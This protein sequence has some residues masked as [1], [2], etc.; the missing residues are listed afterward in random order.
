GTIIVERGRTLR[1]RVVDST[2]RGVAGARVMVG[3]AGVYGGMGRFDEPYFELAGAVTDAA[4]AFSIVG[5]IQIKSSPPMQLVVGADHSSYGR[6]LPV[7]IP[8][9]TQ[10]PP[11]I[12]LTL[13]ECGSIAGKV[14]Q[15]GQP[16]VG[17]TIGAG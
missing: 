8:S 13:Q 2:G 5:G 9:G 14:T 11:P 3:Y 7:A 6:A 12:T 17:A 16:V 10:D 15:S 1:G 4:G